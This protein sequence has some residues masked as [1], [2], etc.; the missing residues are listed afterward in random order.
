MASYQ[1]S[2]AG[3]Q[4]SSVTETEQEGCEISNGTSSPSIVTALQFEFF[5]KEEEKRRQEYR[6]RV[7]KHYC[8]LIEEEKLSPESASLLSDAFAEA[9]VQAKYGTIKDKLEVK[10]EYHTGIDK[11]VWS[12]IDHQRSKS[13]ERL[14]SQGKMTDSVSC[15]DSI[16]KQCAVS[17]NTNVNMDVPQR[18]VSSVSEPDSFSQESD[19]NNGVEYSVNMNKPMPYDGRAIDSELDESYQRMENWNEINYTENNPSEDYDKEDIIHISVERYDDAVESSGN[20]ASCEL[21]S[22]YTDT[23]V[24]SDTDNEFDGKERE[25]IN[26]RGDMA[27]EKSMDIWMGGVKGDLLE[28]DEAGR[29]VYKDKMRQ[30]KDSIAAK[31]RE[32]IRELLKT[33]SAVPSAS[34]TPL[35]YDADEENSYKGN[36]SVDQWSDDDISED[37]NEPIEEFKSAD[38]FQPPMS[39]RSSV[40]SEKSRLDPLTYQSYTAGLLHSSGKSEKFL[41]LQKHYEV[42]ERITEIE[43]KT[44]IS[45]KTRAWMH[46]PTL[47]NELF[48]KYDVQSME[49][50]Q[51]LYQELSDAKK[52]AEFFYDLQRL[53]VYQW[54]PAND[55]GLNKKGKSLSDL[56]EF[57]ETI[58]KEEKASLSNTYFQKAKESDKKLV[59]KKDGSQKKVKHTQRA[60]YG[61]NIPEKPD[62]F[63]IY[64]EEKKGKAR[65]DSNGETDNLHIR[66]MSAPYSKHL[67][68]DKT[69]KRSDSSKGSKFGKIANPDRHA[70]LSKK[71]QIGEV[72]PV[73]RQ[74]SQKSPTVFSNIAPGPH[75]FASR[76]TESASVARTMQNNLEIYNSLEN[77]QYK[78]SVGM[79]VRPIHVTRKSSLTK[80]TD[81]T[82]P[83]K[84]LKVVTAS[85]SETDSSKH[86]I[87]HI[88]PSCEIR[89]NAKVKYDSLAN[90]NFSSKLLNNIP[91]NSSFQ[92]HAIHSD[93]IFPVD[94]QRKIDY[95]PINNV[96]SVIANWEESKDSRQ[97]RENKREKSNDY[98]VIHTY[99]DLLQSQSS[100]LPVSYAETSDTFVTNNKDSKIPLSEY[101]KSLENTK[102]DK[103]TRLDSNSKMAA[104]FKVR[105]LRSL[106]VNNMF[107]ESKFYPS[108]SESK[109]ISPTVPAKTF[110]K[111]ISEPKLHSPVVSQIWHGNTPQ[112]TDNVAVDGDYDARR[113][114]VSSTDTFIVKESDDELENMAQPINDTEQRLFPQIKSKSPSFKLI[115]Q[116][117]KSKSVPDFSEI[118]EPSRPRSAKSYANL[119]RDDGLLNG[120]HCVP[121]FTS[122]DSMEI[123]LKDD[124]N[125]YFTSEPVQSISDHSSSFTNDGISNSYHNR[126]I[127]YDAYIPPVEILKDVTRSAETY[128]RTEP[129]D[130]PKKPSLVGKMTLDYLQE[131]GSEWQ[132]SKGKNRVKEKRL[133]PN[134]R[135][136]PD[137]E[138]FI[139]SDVSASPNK[140][141]PV[142]E[143]KIQ[144]S[145]ET[146]KNPNLDMVHKDL[147]GS[148]NKTKEKTNSKQ[149][150]K[151]EYQDENSMYKK[152]LTL[153]RN[154]Q[155]ERPEGYK[156]SDSYSYNTLPRTKHGTSKGVSKSH[157]TD[158]KKE[159][160]PWVVLA[161]LHSEQPKLNR[162]LAVL[163]A[164]G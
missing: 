37:E 126:E 29:L 120:R 10:P 76:N 56:K 44:H 81:N 47:K 51:W 68:D 102:Q 130:K 160:Y 61:T 62:R 106:A 79:D 131:L 19:Y 27:V 11:T 24:E 63:E 138:P 59:G 12:A 77:P 30:Y 53:A 71:P 87:A 28:I 154:K 118:T 69:H 140:W 139:G 107:S 55:F 128:R 119:D 58:E 40:S 116:V 124:Y 74:V 32:K 145:N 70:N 105:D 3:S 158:G 135:T 103:R 60:L 31:E 80:V 94:K 88:E 17:S 90:E 155:K 86:L 15:N 127:S 48:A 18:T 36:I 72:M 13:F 5:D 93:I 8:R 115:P 122:G 46:N 152:Y 92:A 129:I 97:Q 84:D 99:P 16:N 49:E 89:E 113:G 23:L 9:E 95:S 108:Q 104:S 142:R 65:N 52:N 137:S 35:D 123:H 54:K 21:E 33:S 112:S 156:A 45:G 132:T 64:V 41:K 22:D 111:K 109:A 42:L 149:S 14:K 85:V 26:K 2:F 34:P 66:S 25:F 100:H 147:T 67:K 133:L 143:T 153:P 114:S 161:L 98:N 91:D 163:N 164:I 7:E 136:E 6:E 146:K 121:R 96:K 82:L 151:T 110:I 57:Y 148:A 4:D 162:V 50:L 125:T 43:E 144:T 157:S 38:H 83:H 134:D 150:N 78:A 1:T 141:F 101:P 75:D 117:A 159:V 73:Q 20:L 39:S